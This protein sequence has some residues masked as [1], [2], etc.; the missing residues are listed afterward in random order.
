MVCELSHHKAIIKNAS[1]T[2]KQPVTKGQI[3]FDLTYMKNLEQSSSQ[4][5]NV[6]GGHQG[7]GGWAEQGVSSSWGQ[8]QSCRTESSGDGR[9]RQMH[10]HVNVLNAPELYTEKLLRW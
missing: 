3:F 2:C 5:Q 10:P 6:E 9:W 1:A 4:R 7:L 8:F